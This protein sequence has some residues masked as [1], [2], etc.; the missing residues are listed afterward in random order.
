M[1]QR[2]ITH[3]LV[4][5]GALGALGAAPSAGDLASRYAAG[6]AHAGALRSQISART[7][8]IQGYEGSIS[9]LQTRL[10][11]VQQVVTVQQRLLAADARRAASPPIGGRGARGA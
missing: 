7:Q 4:A 10:D 8:Q 2:S 6:Q 5:V 1:P 3:A 9:S 11:Q